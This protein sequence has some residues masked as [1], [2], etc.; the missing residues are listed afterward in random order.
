MNLQGGSNFAKLIS[1]NTDGRAPCVW[2]ERPCVQRKLSCAKLRSVVSVHTSET[3]NQD[4]ETIS[5][6]V[7]PV[8]GDTEVQAVAWLRAKAYYQD[9]QSRFV[10][11]LKKKF[12]RLESESIQMRTREEP[13][14]GAPQC[15]CLVAIEGESS[16]S[17]HVLGCIDIRLP[18]TATTRQPVG[19]PENDAS[20]CYILNV[21]VEEDSRG[22]GLGKKLMRA[23]M[24]RAV[25][26]WGSERMYTHVAADNEVAYRLYTS[27]GF[28]QF[29][30]DSQY[31]GALALGRLV[32]LQASAE[33]LN[34]E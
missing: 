5:V 2:W 29:S 33:H 6:A 32:L 4:S 23:A 14:L 34:K 21:V 11:S 3:Q 10:E 1:L 15:E 30:A 27:C 16:G 12:S 26:K 25:I 22:K 31:Q 7:R 24:N 9:D 13:P 20:G 28:K 17:A 8:C 19:V 18:K